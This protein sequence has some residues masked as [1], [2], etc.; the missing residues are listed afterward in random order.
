MHDI[1]TPV[2]FLL[3]LS[4]FAAITT[5]M[6]V[7]GVLPQLAAAFA[8]SPA[9]AGILVSIYALV[10]AVTGPFVTLLTSRLNRKLVLLTILAVLAGSNVVYAL[11]EDFGLTVLF[12]MIPAALHAPLFAAALAV[13]AQMSSQQLR[14]RASSQVFAGVAVGLVLGIPVTAFVADA[15]S[16]SAA[17]GFGALVSLIAF[18]G[19]LLWMPAPSAGVK[20]SYGAQLGVLRRGS[21]W[22]NLASVTLIFAGMFS[23]YSYFAEYLQQI[24]R[25]SHAATSGLLMLFGAAGMGG[26][27]IFGRLLERFATRATVFYPVALIISYGLVYLCGGS[28]HAM[29]ALVVVWGAVHSGGLIVSQTWLSRETTAAPEFGNS[30][31]MSFS[32]VGITLGAMLGGA[33]ITWLGLDQLVLSGAAFLVAALISIGTKV[34]YDARAG[35]ELAGDNPPS[36]SVASLR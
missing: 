19:I 1:R 14:T 30:L 20:L 36:P 27:W 13:A 5:E 28:A 4:V 33:V 6:G 31:Y 24:T 12:R 17:F 18:C 8:M 23:V 10:V 7:I 2:L 25:L 9:A 3:G 22:W 29:T 15:V 21:V 16:L 26:N 34:A 11:S 32:N 35:A